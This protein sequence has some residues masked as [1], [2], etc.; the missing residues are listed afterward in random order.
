MAT[1]KRPGVDSLR[2]SSSALTVPGIILMLLSDLVREQGGTLPEGF[3]MLEVRALSADALTL[4]G[5]GMNAEGNPE[6]FRVV[7]ASTP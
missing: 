5:N 7:L 2:T 3:R 1:A 6:G 4:V